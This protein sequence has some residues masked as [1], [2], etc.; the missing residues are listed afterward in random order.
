[1]IR[2]VLGAVIGILLV[3]LYQSKRAREEA[4]RR[5]ESA[6]ES[7]R[8]AATSAKTVSADQ[9]GRV[10]QA[11]DTASVPQGLKD[12]LGRA[13]TAARSTAGRL[14]GGPAED[15]DATPTEGEHVNGQGAVDLPQEVTG[16]QA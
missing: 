2:V 3:W 14:G 10:V 5:W 13:T 11:V 1:M 15:S 12:A 9:F 16:G 8:Q 4:Q 6:P 7:W